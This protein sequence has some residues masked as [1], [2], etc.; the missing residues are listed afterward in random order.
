MGKPSCIR[1]GW[2]VQASTYY[3]RGSRARRGT[4]LSGPPVHP[5]SGGEPHPGGGVEPRPRA[6]PEALRIWAGS[7]MTAMTDR[8]DSHGG[9]A[10]TSSSWTLVSSRLPAAPVRGSARAKADVMSPGSATSGG[11]GCATAMPGSSRGCWRGFPASAFS[12]RTRAAQAV[13]VR[14]PPGPPDPVQ[15]YQVRG[16]TP[17]GDGGGC[18][19]HPLVPP[20]RAPGYGAGPARC[21]G[22][23]SQDPRARGGACRRRD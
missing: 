17:A 15:G 13:G 4:T 18:R 20:D 9:Q 12:P 10:I 8:R 5:R 7:V 3:L 16:G 6:A 19:A 2:S 23:R 22:G 14:S 21:Q 11:T 1:R